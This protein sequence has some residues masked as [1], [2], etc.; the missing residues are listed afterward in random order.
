M[1]SI[2]FK[3]KSD[4]ETLEVGSW[5]ESP[6]TVF[7]IKPSVDVF[8]Q[9]DPTSVEPFKLSPN[10]RRSQQGRS[11]SVQSSTDPYGSNTTLSSTGSSD[12]THP[13]HSSN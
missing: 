1:K 10:R 2:L 7:G 6:V 5:K 4:L 3:K 12:E 13:R 9:A 8:W 11:M